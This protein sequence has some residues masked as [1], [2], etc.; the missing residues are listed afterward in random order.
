MRRAAS[1]QATRQAT[2]PRL[3]YRCNLAASLGW[4]ASSHG[5]RAPRCSSA[6]RVATSP[7]QAAKQRRATLIGLKASSSQA[8]LSRV[9]NGWEQVAAF[10]PARILRN[11]ATPLECLEPPM[12][13]GAPVGRPRR[14]GQEHPRR[15][16]QHAGSASRQAASPLCSRWATTAASVSRCARA[17]RRWSTRH[18]IQLA[19]A[20]TRHSTCVLV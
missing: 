14:R 6:A 7:R 3:R 17:A 12:A 1:G 13:S 18:S 8:W 2:L 11:A 9:G 5:R 15:R 20:L 10:W 19:W 4:A 16:F